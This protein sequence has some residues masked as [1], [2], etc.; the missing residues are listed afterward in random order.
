MEEKFFN[1]SDPEIEDKLEQFHEWIRK[2]PEL[3][4]K[5]GKN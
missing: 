1:I 3:P 2:H 5:I 4:Q